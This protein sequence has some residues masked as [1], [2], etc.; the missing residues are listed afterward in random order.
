MPRAVSDEKVKKYLGL[1]FEGYSNEEACRSTGFSN[2]TGTN[3]LRAFG[4][5][6]RKEGL[7]SA[8]SRYDLGIDDLFKL[9]ANL[10]KEDIGVKQC[11][12]GLSIYNVLK[13]LEVGVSQ[14][15]TFVR[16]VFLETLDQGVNNDELA[17][18]LTEFVGIRKEHGLSY[19][20][21]TKKF[22]YYVE[23][24]VKLEASVEELEKKSKALNSELNRELR[25]ADA[26]RKVLK[27]YSTTKAALKRIWISFD[28]LEEI[29]TLFE[30]MAG[31]GYD[32]NRIV[33][34]Y[35]THSELEE[36]RQI[37]ERNVHS[38][39][40]EKEAMEKKKSRLEVIIREKGEVVESIRMLEEQRLTPENTRVLS[41]AV[42]AIG[43]K[44]GLASGEA[45]TRLCKEI[46]EHFYPLL[47]LRDE[48]LRRDAELTALKIVI[49]EEKRNLDLIGD[50]Y[51]SK[52]EGF[53][54]LQKMNEAGV[55]DRDLGTWTSIL[56]DFQM[57][58]TELRRAIKKMGSLEKIVEEKYAKHRELEEKIAQ[59]SKVHS[60]LESNLKSLTS[61]TVKQV[62]NDL[63]RFDQILIK[64]ESQFLSDETGFNAE[65]T[66]IL[67]E[68][69]DRILIS[70]HSTETSWNSRMTKFSK[71]LDAI[72]N[73]VK[74]T[75]DLAYDTGKEVERFST[76]N[77]I[78]K[79]MRGEDIR[80][81][82]VIA[83]LHAITTNIASW[84]LRNHE[85]EIYLD[86]SNLKSTLTK[87]MKNV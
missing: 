81:I 29:R 65:T 7:M 9:A 72:I 56:Q 52:R 49:E 86:C 11:K 51:D 74:E 5:T 10:R 87:R 25:D 64:F 43:S 55:S 13:R 44:Y 67:E 48:S 78:S 38:L 21:V 15:E 4:E 83:G 18:A 76:V 47:S 39:S 12:T 40:D 23:E 68:A 37:L 26:T 42:A 16:D 71:E 69:R 85:N 61:D 31:M 20:Q 73:E 79:I 30:N 66:R 33:D 54:A 70:L 19:N 84:A 62:E 22:Y 59:L 34:F 80:K 45:L 58:P 41:E 77:M 57:D 46:D 32:P 60:Q 14:F 1:R 28:N 53:D 50:V 24:R 3:K 2:R 17:V 27:D 82:E 75:R 36:S 35:T 8:T 6:V 63:R